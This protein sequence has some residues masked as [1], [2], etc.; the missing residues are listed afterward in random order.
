MA[1]VPDAPTKF[2]PDAPPPDP[3]G[4]ANA[5]AARTEHGP[6]QDVIDMIRAAP[7]GI[8]PALKG[9]V[10]SLNP[11]ENVANLTR[12]IHSVTADPDAALSALKNAT[13]QQV[14]KNVL[15]PALVGAGVNELGGAAAG[16]A[17]T[18]AA[19]AASAPPLD[20]RTGADNPI[21]RNVAGES[22]QPAVAAHNQA[23]AEPA[24]G[25][26]AGVPPGTPINP[27]TLETARE[28]P[29]SVYQR[30]EQALPTGPLS[31]NAA[32]IVNSVGAD[33]LVV[34]SPNVQAQIDAQKERLLSGNLTG[35]QVVNAQRTL[36]FNGFK[37]VNSLDPEQQAIGKAQLTFS[38]ALHQHMLDTLQE[39][40]PVSAD[41]LNAAR[42]ALAQ[43]HTVENLISA[44]GNLDL[45]KLAKLHRDN[46]KLLTG[47]MA[48]IAQFASDHPEVTSLP[49]NAERFNPSGV[50]KD[51]AAVNPLKP[52][53]FS[54][55]F[56]G[57]AARSRLTGGAPPTPQVPVTGLGGEFGPLAPRQP[58]P[59]DLRPPPGQAFT[60]HQP[61]AATG[62]PQRDFFGTGA[63]NF[64]ASPP[65]APPAPAAG[66]PGQISLADLLSH[67]VEQPPP[68]GLSVGPMGAPAPSGIPFT[69]DA[70][71]TA[72]DLSLG[73]TPFR[74]QPM[75]MSDFAG[76]KSQGVPEDIMTRTQNN[77]SG[78]SA[79]SVEAIN[80]GKREQ[81][82]GQD[83]FLVDPD[84][85]MWPVRGVEAADAKAPPGSIIIQKGV[86]GTPY[87]ILDRGGLPSS[88]AKGLMNRALAGGR[89]LSL[90][91]LL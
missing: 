76:V 35:P 21:A 78:E 62:A 15:A 20:M 33:D 57:A 91:D 82:L 4:E 34:R 25:A 30:A 64:T 90:G 13:P 23:I 19:R 73:G 53:T 5:A 6:V 36:R 75:P 63:D 56:F 45:Q 38:D 51:I 81:A 65:T 55:P 66:P 77:A 46:P 52:V 58:P 37:G 27:Q 2:V 50:V 85:K 79:A 83:R 31:P 26:Q 88:H 18:A 70:A 47:P 68:V 61:E 49:S 41:Q 9:V 7:S 10:S 80:R 1:F 74:G 29:N 87:T 54:Q 8:I 43:N 39:N 24:L 71:H 11:L 40:A 89:G 12:A 69:R 14:G 22:A 59:L 3:V 44:G 67:G 16:M 42:T 72:G 28:A 32:G 48:D 86:G 17:D 60:P 84:G